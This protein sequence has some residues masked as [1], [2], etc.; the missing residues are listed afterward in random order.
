VKLVDT[1]DLKSAAFLHKGRTGSIPVPGTTNFMSFSSFLPFQYS[2]D[3]IECLMNRGNARPLIIEK[4][5][6]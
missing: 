2:F 4:I 1:A 3:I 6:S 5:I